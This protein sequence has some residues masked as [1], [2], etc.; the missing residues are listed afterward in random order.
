MTERNVRGITDGNAMRNV[1]GVRIL[2][3]L[4]SCLLLSFYVRVIANEFSIATETI[5][6]DV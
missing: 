3:H 6:I 5:V 4:S 2:L 1:H